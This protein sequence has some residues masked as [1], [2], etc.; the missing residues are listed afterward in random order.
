M[1]KAI[2]TVPLPENEPVT[3]FAPGTSERDRLLAVYKEMYSSTIDVPMYIGGKETTTDD[4][5]VISPPHDHQHVLGHFNMGDASHVNL[6]IDSALAAREEW[7]SMT[8]E[9]RAAIFLKAADLLAGPYRA[10]MN[11]STMLAQSKNCMQAEI[12]AACELIDFFK[13]NVAYVT[14]IYEDQPSSNEGMWNRLEYRPL[15]GFVFVIS[16]FN[17]T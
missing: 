12:D 4:K 17:F 7:A 16:P 10:R 3:S 1:P 6:A 15:E 8:W 11:A 2:Y 13:F 9:H 5:R 14:Q